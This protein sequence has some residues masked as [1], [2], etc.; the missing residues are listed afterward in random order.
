MQLTC[1]VEINGIMTN[2]DLCREYAVT[3][4]AIMEIEPVIYYGNSL[5]IEEITFNVVRAFYQEYNCDL[6]KIEPPIF[7]QLEKEL[8]GKK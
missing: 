7:K 8:G 3:I 2:Y 4:P 6:I 5:P 1:P